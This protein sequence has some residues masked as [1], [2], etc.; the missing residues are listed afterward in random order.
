MILTK[1]ET[2]AS[3]NG[4]IQIPEG[5]A[6]GGGGVTLLLAIVYTVLS[7]RRRLSRDNVE[8]VKDRTESE[9]ITKLV[10][11]RDKYLENAREAWRTRAE[12]AKRIGELSTQVQHLTEDNENLRRNVKQLR[13]EVTR[14][15][16]LV[17]EHMPSFPSTSAALRNSDAV[18]PIAEAKD[19]SDP[20]ETHG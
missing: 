2:V 16:A 13:T 12:D 8:V 11:E 18:K 17:Q 14:L 3:G 20:G 10:Q 7:L 4:T 15:V 1:N 19:K 5:V 6:V 9:L